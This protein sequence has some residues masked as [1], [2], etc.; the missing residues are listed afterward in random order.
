MQNFPLKKRKVFPEN[1]SIFKD[2]GEIPSFFS[3]ISSFEINELLD[4]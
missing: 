2:L 1:S 4:E 3:I